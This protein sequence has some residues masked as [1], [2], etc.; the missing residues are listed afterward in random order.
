MDQTVSQEEVKP[1][2]KDKIKKLWKIAGFLA[3]VTAFEFVVAF[4]LGAG[5][6]K[7]LIF[8]LLTLVK[9]YYIVSEFMHLGHEVRP[10]VLSIV[11]PTIFIIW[12]IATLIM[13]GGALKMM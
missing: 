2:D 4:T 1:A 3:I 8:V 11:L 10:L 6:I 5:A 7:I 13:Q 12:L 9:A